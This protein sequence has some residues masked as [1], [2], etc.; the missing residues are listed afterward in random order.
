MAGPVAG[1]VAVETDPVRKSRCRDVSVCRVV[2][3]AIGTA[4]EQSMHLPM[5]R[6]QEDGATLP[7]G[8]IDRVSARDQDWRSSQHMSDA[9]RLD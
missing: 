5:L 4:D 7:A 1:L 6:V 9:R 8:V 3:S 2:R